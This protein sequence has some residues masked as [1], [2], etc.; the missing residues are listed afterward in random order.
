VSPGAFTPKK[1]FDR[2]AALVYHNGDEEGSMAHRESNVTGA[3]LAAAAVL[4]LDG[5]LTATKH[6]YEPAT[7]DNVSIGGE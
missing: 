3:P 4:Y 2:R 5:K 6:N 7:E 1:V